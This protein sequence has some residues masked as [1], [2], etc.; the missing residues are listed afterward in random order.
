MNDQY[1]E[2]IND[3]EAAIQSDFIAPERGYYMAAMILKAEG[4]FERALE[5]FEHAA[6][7]NFDDSAAQ[8]EELRQQ[9]S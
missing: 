2:A 9:R 7:T 8:A 6:L 4:K 5:Y 3:Y 1:E